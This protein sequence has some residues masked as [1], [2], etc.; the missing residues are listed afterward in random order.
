[1]PTNA[2]LLD[3]L[4]AGTIDHAAY[5]KGVADNN[6]AREAVAR[7][8]ALAAAGPGVD[9][10]LIASERRLASASHAASQASADRRYEQQRAVE[11]QNAQLRRQQAKI[12]QQ[13]G[14]SSY[15]HIQAQ[16][17]AMD[18]QRRTAGVTRSQ[19]E[20]A[21]RDRR[22]RE[23]ALTSQAI[24]EANQRLYEET[25]RI[26]APEQYGFVAADAIDRARL[27]VGYEL[28]E[29]QDPVYQDVIPGYDMDL[30]ANPL[31]PAPGRPDWPGTPVYPYPGWASPVS[32]YVIDPE[33]DPGSVQPT[34]PTD[35]SDP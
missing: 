2:Q 27:Q 12:D 35:P 4:H 15:A 5:S 17:Q 34:Q 18:A 20:V 23:E 31:E 9:P 16:Q 26:S 28:G 29:L 22:A 13:R 32:F 11:Q 8:N 14:T 1:M 3:Q 10:T 30:A 21:E 7:Q 24:A 33:T 19:I 25:G 6:R